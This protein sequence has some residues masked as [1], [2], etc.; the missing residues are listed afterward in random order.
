ML[1]ELKNLL[2]DPFGEKS[3]KAE[4]DRVMKAMSEFTDDE[5][6]GLGTRLKELKSWHVDIWYLEIAQRW[7][8][9]KLKEKAE[10]KT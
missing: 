7:V 4:I 8:D 10:K 2:R 6:I 5:I 3:R 9:I 1:K